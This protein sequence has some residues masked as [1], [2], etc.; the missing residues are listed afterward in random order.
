M[1]GSSLPPFVCRRVHVLFTLFVFVCVEWCLIHIVLC[2][3]VFHRLVYPSCQFL[4]IIYFRLPLR[5]SLTCIICHV[6]LTSVSDW[7]QSYIQLHQYRCY[8][9]IILNLRDHSQTV[10]NLRCSCSN[11]ILSHLVF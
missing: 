2:F 5:Y 10:D 7:I 6:F 8:I 3:V 11:I 1:F 4:W 9:K